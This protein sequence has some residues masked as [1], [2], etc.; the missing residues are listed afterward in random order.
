MQFFVA[1]QSINGKFCLVG[2]RTTL[3]ILIL[4]IMIY[5]IC[6]HFLSLK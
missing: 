5:D 1:V 4:N 6:I 2:G 3:P